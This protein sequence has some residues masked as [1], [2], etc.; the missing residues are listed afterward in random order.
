MHGSSSTP[1]KPGGPRHDTA[2]SCDADEHSADEARTPH[3]RPENVSTH[4]VLFLVVAVI[5]LVGDD[6]DGCRWRESAMPVRIGWRVCVWLSVV[7]WVPWRDGYRMTDDGKGELAEEKDTRW[8][9][10]VS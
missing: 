5:L 1:A 4:L 8:D 6:A 9:P 7:V 3:S 2:W 10:N